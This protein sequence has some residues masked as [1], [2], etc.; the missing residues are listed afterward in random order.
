MPAPLMHIESSPPLLVPSMHPG[1][2]SRTGAMAVINWQPAGAHA[3][4]RHRSSSGFRENSCPCL[5]AAGEVWRRAA[6]KAG[7]RAMKHLPD[8][9]QAR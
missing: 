6:A 7:G 9:R 5:P 2:R 1:S 3:S 4:T 8:G